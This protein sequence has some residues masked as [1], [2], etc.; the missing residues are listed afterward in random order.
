MQM[1]DRM[2]WKVWIGVISICILVV[3]V[4]YARMM[5]SNEG[6][7]PRIDI[8][9]N[10]KHKRKQTSFNRGE[11]ATKIKFNVMVVPTK[12]QYGLEEAMQP[13]GERS[14][15][16]ARA[17]DLIRDGELEKALIMAEGAIEGY[18]FS[19]EDIAT[20]E[21]LAVCRAHFA[22]ALALYKQ[23]DLDAAIDSLRSYLAS[24]DTDDYFIQAAQWN[25]A[26]IFL[27][28]MR[29]ANREEARFSAAREAATY[30]QIFLNEWPDH[31]AASKA[32]SYLTC[33]RAYLAATEK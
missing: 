2:R 31:P 17:L 18:R 21:T 22:M 7:I 9:T 8:P 26:L 20:L 3:I 13:L 4:V 12:A 23:G 32:R 28:V 16:L 27:E 5:P 14:S 24:V 11:I 29:S 15:R 30:L 19:L 10:V 25:L 33:A 6:H 1:S